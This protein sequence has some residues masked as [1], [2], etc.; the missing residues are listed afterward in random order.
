M[1]LAQTQAALARLYTSDAARAAFARDPAAAAR[2]AGLAGA[3]AQALA[4]VAAREIARF[5]GS[6][7]AKRRLDVEKW[8]PLTAAALGAGFAPRLRAV[9]AE[10]PPGARADALALAA[11]LKGAASPPWIGELA[12]YEARGLRAWGPDAHFAVALYR[13]PVPAIA[14]RLAAGEGV[15]EIAPALTLALWARRRGGRLWRWARRFGR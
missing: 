3:S 5:A 11:S 2:A 6:L 12:D 13:W 1:S 10:P 15:G 9:L 14:A 8:L 4:A 7:A